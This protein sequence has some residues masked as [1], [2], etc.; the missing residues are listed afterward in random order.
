MFL[1]WGKDFQST[2]KWDVWILFTGRPNFNL[3]NI[4]RC[5]GL[6][7][8]ILSSYGRYK[9]RSFFFKQ[10]NT[11]TLHS[12]ILDN[13]NKHVHNTSRNKFPNHN[14][15]GIAVSI[16]VIKL[17]AINLR[18][19]A[20]FQPLFSFGLHLSNVKVNC[21][22]TLNTRNVCLASMWHLLQI[23]LIIITWWT[24]RAIS[25]VSNENTLNI[26]TRNA[27]V[28]FFGRLFFGKSFWIFITV[29]YIY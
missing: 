13:I 28:P 7:R 10:T 5:V 9:L 12:S 29:R 15:R 21:Q 24:S 27:M 1:L 18:Q 8:M 3:Q 6:L 20:Y 4:I 22:N 14:V 2:W 26:P 25:S 19:K 17:F 16:S 23:K 11:H